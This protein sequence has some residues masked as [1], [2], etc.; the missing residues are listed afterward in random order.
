MERVY[1]GTAVRTTCQFRNPTGVLTDP[2]TVT[3]KWRNQGTTTTTWT[4]NSTGHITRVT[5]GVYHATLT[6]ATS[7]SSSW[8]AEWKGTGT[9]AAVSVVS[10]TV[11]PT[12]L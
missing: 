10:F 1:A 2:T 3:L 11:M 7:V 6:T 5:T 9:V 8:T 12:P 4:Y